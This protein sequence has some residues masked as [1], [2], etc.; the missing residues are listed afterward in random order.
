MEERVANE[1]DN[2]EEEAKSDF[3]KELVR[4]RASRSIIH[5]ET[6]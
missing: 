2:E 5:K 1:A 4:R 3:L 6:A